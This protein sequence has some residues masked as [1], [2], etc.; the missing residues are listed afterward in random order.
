MEPP[1]F[2]LATV[3]APFFE[4][5][6]GQKFR[7]WFTEGPADAP[8]LELELMLV[9]PGHFRQGVET[10]AP[11]S[12]LFKLPEGVRPGQGIY[13]CEGP[14][15]ERTEI[16]LVPVRDALRGVCMEAVFN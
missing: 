3:E 13:E 12:L 16:F 4:G 1:P 2:D 10:R 14:R 15:L 5:L 11:F 6:T 7:A 9:Q 8:P